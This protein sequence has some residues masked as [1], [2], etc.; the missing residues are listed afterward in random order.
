M[1]IID[2]QE[3]QIDL[4]HAYLCGVISAKAYALAS[5]EVGAKI[6]AMLELTP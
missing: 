1:S 6:A 4:R 3:L 2:L 5:G